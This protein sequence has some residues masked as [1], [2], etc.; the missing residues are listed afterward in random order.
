MFVDGKLASAT[1]TRSY[2]IA[3]TA[4]ATQSTLTEPFYTTRIDPTGSI[5][6]GFS[7]VNSWYNSMVITLRRAMSHGLEFTMNY[8]LAKATDGGHV[9]GQFG[10]FNGT[11]PA[12]HPHNRNVEHALPDLDQ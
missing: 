12:L 10:T 5:L 2:D 11:D 6:A 7:D 8:T 3:S 9:P 4:G 1:E